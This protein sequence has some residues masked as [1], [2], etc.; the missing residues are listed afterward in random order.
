MLDFLSPTTSELQLLLTL[1]W[2]DLSINRSQ[3]PRLTRSE[4]PMDS[5]P[6]WGANEPPLQEGFI[7]LTESTMPGAGVEPA[8]SF[9][10]RGFQK[11]HYL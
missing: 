9:R 2:D 4:N 10:S 3:T 8:R 7:F 11:T 6:S 5:A 1:D